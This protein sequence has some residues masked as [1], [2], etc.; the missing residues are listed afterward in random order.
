MTAPAQ[1]S[2]FSPLQPHRPAGSLPRLKQLD[3]SAMTATILAVAATLALSTAQSRPDHHG[4]QPDSDVPVSL[5]RIRT[6]LEKPP[7]VLSVPARP[8]ERSTF[9]VDVRQPL[10]VL[11]PTHE[12]ALDPTLGLPSI[13]ELLMGGI[14]KI[15]SAAVGYKRSRAERRARR[16]V[17]EALAAFC[18]VHGCATPDER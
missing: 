4:G 11:R 2:P 6:G 1:L 8:D 13:G 7:P 3:G 9:R 10:W 18:A 16:E 14:A 15:H 12:E 17:D 5:D